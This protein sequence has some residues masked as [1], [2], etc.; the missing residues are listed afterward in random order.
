[1]SA[2]DWEQGIDFERLRAYRRDRLDR[3][4]VEAGIDALMT[5]SVDHVRYMTSFRAITVPN[6][7]VSRYASVQKAGEGLPYL[8]VASGDLARAQYAM[9]W[10]EGRIKPLPMDIRLGVN[11]FVGVLD[12]MGLSR[13][14]IGVDNVQFQL[15][16]ELAAAR[17]DL[18]FVDGSP[19][20]AQA[21][22]IKGPEEIELLRQASII[23]EIGM[24]ECIDAIHEGVSEIQVAAVGQAAMTLA[25]SEGGHH[26]PPFVASGENTV[27]LTRFPTQRRI[28]NGD[29]VLLD[30]GCNYG[31]YQSDYART[32]ICGEPNEKQ[33]HMYTAVLNALRAAIAQ[34]RS[35][36]CASE[37]DRASRNVLRDAGYEK[38]WYYGVTGHGIGITL[39]EPPIVGEAVASGGR[40]WVLEPGMVFSLEPSVHL[41]NVGGVRLEDTV[42]VTDGDPEVLTRTPFDSAL[43]QGG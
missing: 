19:A 4:M 35:G 33:R 37:V 40:D 6:F 29:V 12:K 8:L 2:Y 32:V 30:I 22:V 11:T 39:H 36:M 13:A 10:M 43:Y 28:R 24:R 9:P 38:Y 31:G 20:L 25:G 5:T 23:G 18:T 41:P 1:M 34:C 16:Q 14:R 27:R 3:A 21:K 7:Y 26:Q 15:I 17:P 42:V